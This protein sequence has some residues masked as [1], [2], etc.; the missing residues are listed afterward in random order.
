[1]EVINE[2]YFGKTKEVLAIE[3]AIGE[4][5]RKYQFKSDYDLYNL[6]EK[7]NLD[8]N[9]KKINKAFEDAFGFGIVDFSFNFSPGCNASTVPI[10][11]K[12]DADDSNQVQITPTGYKFNKKAD[13]ALQVTAW[14]GLFAG[15]DF[16]DGEITAVLLHEVGHNF[17]G[18]I[19][20][21]IGLIQALGKTLNFVTTVLNLC[22][23]NPIPWL[24]LSNSGSKWLIDFKKKLA[25]EFPDLY[26]FSQLA[27]KW[28][29]IIFNM[30]N[31]LI[32]IQNLM[33][34]VA[35]PLNAIHVLLGYFKD[36]LMVWG[37][38]PS[39]ILHE[40]YGYSDEKFAD[41]FTTMYGYGPEL[42][43]ALDKMSASYDGGLI[44]K[45]YVKNEMPALAMLYDICFLPVLILI[46]SFDCHP[47]M[48]ERLE[49]SIRALKVEAEY[50]KNPKMR[51]RLKKDIAVLEKQRDDYYLQAQIFKK[52]NKELDPG[53]FTR[54][55]FAAI[56][57][58]FGGDIRHHIWD[59][60]FKSNEVMTTK[61]DEE[62][63]KAHKEK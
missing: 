38:F 36:K 28:I 63:R 52:K 50:S 2:A 58:L 23:L 11:I 22:I 27:Q 59:R 49:S 55:Y 45:K 3:K 16:T 18:A 32:F 1:M 24:L 47:A 43:S 39:M 40:L 41:Q 46:T 21:R 44:T 35:I 26:N 14:Y 29:T 37:L 34:C 8:P 6:D 30:K 54:V 31:E 5:R 20:H 51:D 42:H 62:W 25:K 13:F 4:F 19:N 61:A 10:S 33:T 48:I 57:G 9:I 56:F 7:I 17:S 53:Y 12:Y 15:K 60:I